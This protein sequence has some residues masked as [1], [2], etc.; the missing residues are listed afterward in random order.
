[1]KGGGGGSSAVADG[2][3]GQGGKRGFEGRPSKRSVS[4]WRWAREKEMA[5]EAEDGRE[6]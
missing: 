5:A 2:G 4:S 6:R 1:M 3:G